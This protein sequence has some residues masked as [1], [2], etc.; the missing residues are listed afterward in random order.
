MTA[1]RLWWRNR[2]WTAVLLVQAAALVLELLGSGLILAIPPLLAGAGVEV[3]NGAVVPLLSAIATGWALSRPDELERPS[4]RPVRWWDV[5][6]V[7]VLVASHGLLMMSRRFLD[8]AALSARNAAGLM[9]LVLLVHVAGWADRAGGVTSAFLIAC[10]LCGD[11]R[12]GHAWWSW[13]VKPVGDLGA[14][15]LAALVLVVGAGA[16]ISVGYGLTPFARRRTPR[17]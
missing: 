3:G 17:S 9:G 8:V 14:A 15:S 12:P 6:M 1:V 5:G 10:L 7:V 4:A 11:S 16:Y 13:P 2:G